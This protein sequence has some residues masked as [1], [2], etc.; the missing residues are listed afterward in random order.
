M[1]SSPQ[2][3]Q[4][5]TNEKLLSI[6]TLG[7]L[8]AAGYQSKT[9]K[10][11]LRNNL[12]TKLKAKEP[13][14]AGIHGYEETVIPDMQRAIL[15]MHDINLLGLRGQAKTRIAPTNGGIVR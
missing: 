5:L 4:K 7:A 14:F 12:I 1:S 11:E 9:V 6:H 3:Y 8:K 13:V 10:Q 15:S 2:E